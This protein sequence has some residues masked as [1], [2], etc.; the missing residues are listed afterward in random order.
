MSRPLEFDDVVATIEE[1]GSLATLVTI[2]AEGDAHVGTVLVAI[3]DGRLDIDVGART[4]GN[5]LARPA[6]TLVW[7][8]PDLDYQLILDGSADLVG[9][10]SAD[11]LSAVSVCVERG[12]LHRLAGRAD[13]GPSCLALSQH[14]TA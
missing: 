13:A 12:I 10:P 5:L 4:R 9:A 2:S 1:F 7:T 14:R 3:A 11:G 8:H 6:V